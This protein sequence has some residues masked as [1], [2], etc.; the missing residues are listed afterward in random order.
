MSEPLIAS[1]ARRHEVPDED[2][3]HAFRN[4]VRSFDLGEGLTM[5]IGPARNAALLEVGV[6]DKPDGPE[7]VHAMPR[8]EKFLRWK[9]G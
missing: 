2:I 9:R 6:S 5:L 7:I 3:L 1:S 4:P 8:R